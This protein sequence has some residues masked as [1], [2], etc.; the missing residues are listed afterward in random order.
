M[1]NISRGDHIEQIAAHEFGPIKNLQQQRIGTLLADE[2]NA[3]KDQL[4]FLNPSLEYLNTAFQFLAN[5]NL[6]HDPEEVNLYDYVRDLV[7]INFSDTVYDSVELSQ[8]DIKDLSTVICHKQP[9]MLALSNIFRNA[10]DAVQQ[11]PVEDRNMI[12]TANGLKD[13]HIKVEHKKEISNG[14]VEISVYDSAKVL[15]DMKF[16]YFQS[17]KGEGHGIGRGFVADLILSM[18]GSVRYEKEPQK[19]VVITL[20]VNNFEEVGSEK[21]KIKPSLVI[22]LE[23]KTQDQKVIVDRL[24]GALED[25]TEII[26]AASIEEALKVLDERKGSLQTPP[27][28]TV[29]SEVK[30]GFYGGAISSISGLF[31]SE[32]EYRKPLFALIPSLDVPESNLRAE[33][34]S[35]DFSRLITSVNK[36]DFT[37]RTSQG[38]LLHYS[39]YV[40]EH[41]LSSD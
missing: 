32:P 16:D 35:Q 10:L 7:R 41:G 6:N 2:A 34:S 23:D 14:S 30:D 17:S 29:D 5:R 12:K 24:R 21:I 8:P 37:S 31:K 28:I 9:L 13:I 40:E 19:R 25:D 39:N 22:C 33:L 11:T 20:P 38:L 3:S 26:A 18:G 1:F 36:G 15:D 4:A 27:L